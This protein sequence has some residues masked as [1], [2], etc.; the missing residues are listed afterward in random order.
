MKEAHILKDEFF[1]SQCLNVSREALARGAPDYM[2]EELLFMALNALSYSLVPCD[3]D[4]EDSL[5]YTDSFVTEYIED[6]LNEH[7]QGNPRL[8]ELANALKLK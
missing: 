5:A 1:F 3:S 4:E 2:A 8:G 6:Y 7:Y